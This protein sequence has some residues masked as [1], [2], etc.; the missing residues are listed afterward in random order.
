MCKTR[1]RRGK[2]KRIL[3][4]YRKSRGNRK[5]KR[6]S[7]KKRGGLPPP[8]S[9]EE[10]AR[11]LA[12]GKDIILNYIEEGNIDKLETLI[13]RYNLDVNTKKYDEPLLNI[14]IETGNEEMV[15]YLLGKGAKVTQTG[16]ESPLMYAVTVLNPNINI[17]EH[18]I[19]Y[20]GDPFLCHIR[21]RNPN[22]YSTP[23][24]VVKEY[25]ADYKKEDER[26]EG[27]LAVPEPRSDEAKEYLGDYN[28]EENDKKIKLYE[29]IITILT[30]VITH[31]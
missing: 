14:A 15:R 7:R 28:K 27:Y 6:N 17:I 18:L 20:G 30:S 11:R 13:T 31:D 9:P 1:R 25:L 19:Q 23:F 21:S 24:N 26:A 29:D 8:L 5:S 12:E 4:K 10:R 22:T 3:K 16:A 2:S